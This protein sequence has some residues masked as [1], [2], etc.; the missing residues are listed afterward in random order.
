MTAP[1][2]NALD[3]LARS[4][5]GAGAARVLHIAAAALR[6]GDALLVPHFNQ[7]TEVTAAEEVAAVG[8]GDFR[9]RFARD[10]PVLVLR[11][12]TP[13]APCPVCRRTWT[14]GCASTCDGRVLWAEEIAAA[15]A[16]FVLASNALP[17]QH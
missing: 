6:V 5:P 12:G 7:L 16:A 10:E 13:D 14:D 17:V 2:T 4:R 9:H 1:Q 8:V 11:P 3:Q 15:L